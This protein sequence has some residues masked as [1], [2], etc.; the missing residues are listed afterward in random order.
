M[1]L[2]ELLDFRFQEVHSVR[3]C[4]QQTA[5]HF[6]GTKG[7][8]KLLLGL[9][10]EIAIQS[11]SIKPQN[12][13]D[14]SGSWRVY[15]D[16]ILISTSTVSISVLTFDDLNLQWDCRSVTF[17]ATAATHTIKFIP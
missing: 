11:I 10:L 5:E 16:G 15:L 1:P 6:Y 17:T 4:I 14:E 13:L 3:D 9:R 7:L 2:A 12:A 8:C